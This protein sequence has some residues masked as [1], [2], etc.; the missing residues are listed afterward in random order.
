MRA[1]LETGAPLLKNCL[2]Q[3]SPKQQ[4]SKTKDRR[5]AHAQSGSAIG[6]L[7]EAAPNNVAVEKQ[8]VAAGRPISIQVAR[9]VIGHPAAV[10]GPAALDSGEVVRPVLID[11]RIDDHFAF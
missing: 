11:S 6:H 8:E 4:G 9:A 5:A 10:I 3:K 7:I 2:S 1:G